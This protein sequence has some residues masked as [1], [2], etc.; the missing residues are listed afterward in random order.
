V[1]VT[2]EPA[3]AVNVY[4]SCSPSASIVD[5]T[6]CPD[7]ISTV[8]PGGTCTT[9]ASTVK[10]IVL[11][12]RPPTVTCTGPV[13]AAAGTAAVSVV[14]DAT[15]TADGTPANVTRFFA[16]S[17]S[18]PSPRIATTVPGTPRPGDRP[19]IAGVIGRVVAGRRTPPLGV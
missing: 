18:K 14:V 15:I 10:S 19:E 2:T 12:A 17:G 6:F 4:R 5:C 16:G 9:G 11:L 1:T 8:P 13:D 7:T 3:R